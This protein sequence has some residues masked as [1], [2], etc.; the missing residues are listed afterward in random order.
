MKPVDE[1][2]KLLQD[3]PQGWRQGRF[4]L[5][6]ADT[7]I[8]IWTANGMLFCTLYTPKRNFGLLSRLRLWCAVCRWHRTT[9]VVIR[10]KDKV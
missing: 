3:D 10:K 8:E 5:R 2:I 4:D 1:V 6:H 7:G 9:S